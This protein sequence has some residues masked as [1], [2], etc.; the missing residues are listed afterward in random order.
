MRFSVLSVHSK[1]RL[2]D[3]H[4]AIMMMNAN[5]YLH[6]EMFRGHSNIV[7]GIF[8]TRMDFTKIFVMSLDFADIKY[9]KNMS[10]GMTYRTH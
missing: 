8:C 4:F 7:Y 9:I 5:L 1:S 3:V 10:M 6:F 2:S